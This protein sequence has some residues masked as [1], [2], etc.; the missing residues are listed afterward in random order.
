MLVFEAKLEGTKQQYD[1]LD[2]AI[3]TARFV[4]NSCIRY[5]MENQG[6]GRYELSAY[7]AVLAKEF[8]WAGQLNSMARQA[9]AERAWR[10]ISRFYD[11]C[12]KAKPGKKGFPR[13][14][15]HQTHGSVEYKT[16]G[17]KLSQDRRTIDFT[18]GFAAGSFKLWGTRNLHFYQLKQIKRVRVVRRADGYYCQFC[19][20]CERREQR[21]LT[22]KT[23]G[24][25]VGL[26]HFYTDSNGH[27]VDNPR[28]LRKSEKT[29]KR[30]ARKLSRTQ[31]GSKNRIKARNRLSRK[32]LKVSRQRKDFAIKQALCAVQSNDLVAYEDLQVRN[33]VKNKKLSKSI[34]DAA[35]S[36]FRWW[37]EY[38]GKVFGVATVAVSPHYTSQ[39]CSN[40]GAIVKKSLSQRTHRCPDCGHVQDR[41]WNAAINI[42]ELALRTVGHTGTNA[43]GDIDLCIG[44]ETPQCKSSRRK[45]KL[46]EQSLESPSF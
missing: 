31:L 1:R 17:W 9:S 10:A 19:I 35:W 14:K 34:S 21:E 37:L 26:T 24:I 5:W 30:L 18:D 2:E 8:P 43:S 32:H 45:R 15:K 3:R 20:E 42:L 41:D 7:C 16:T 36:A 27:T 23:V 12:K 28:H 29:L 46:Q 40:C 38:F 13:F 22:G 39:R 6:V 25:D 44:G 11:N 4:R 33:M